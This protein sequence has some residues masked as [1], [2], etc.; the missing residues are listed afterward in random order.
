MFGDMSFD[1]SGND[2]A[3]LSQ[4]DDS[5][6]N[7]L[8]NMANGQQPLVSHQQFAR[9]LRSSK[10]L[11]DISFDRV[12]DD[13]DSILQLDSKPLDAPKLDGS[14]V[15]HGANDIDKLFDSLV[16]ELDQFGTSYSV[17]STGDG[18]HERRTT[19]EQCANDD[20][21]PDALFDSLFDE[22]DHMGPSRSDTPK[23][24]NA[25]E[26]LAIAQDQSNGASERGAEDSFDS[27]FD[28][29]DHMGPSTPG[30]DDG[31]EKAVMVGEQLNGN[32][33][34]AKV[35]SNGCDS[36]FEAVIEETRVNSS[37]ESL[38]DE[39]SPSRE[40]HKS[41]STLDTFSIRWEF[42]A[43]ALLI[44]SIAMMLGLR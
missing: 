34:C 32:G 7:S 31:S 22:L 2:S 19:G 38:L 11:Q 10:E 27:L 5:G 9:D 16:D 21:N 24:C 17:N 41:A 35:V 28:E 26:K 4:K 39:D 37:L 25:V 36:H 30:A 18:N 12:D 3:S 13:L 8:S 42:I 44:L 29:L 1:C 40:D 15:P 6:L 23:W 20:R 33:M 14:D 43:L